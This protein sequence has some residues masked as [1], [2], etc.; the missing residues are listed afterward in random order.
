MLPPSPIGLI[1]HRAS[2]DTHHPKIKKAP[3]VS[4]ASIQIWKSS[5]ADRQARRQINLV[6]FNLQLDELLIIAAGIDIMGVIIQH[7]R[8]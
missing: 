5:S 7:P 2:N 3:L 1:P 4:G 6:A 8:G